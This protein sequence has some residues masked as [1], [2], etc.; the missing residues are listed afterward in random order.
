MICWTRT[1]TCVWCEFMANPSTVEAQIRFALSQLPAHNAHH[2]FEHICRYLTQQFICSN[3]LPATG[4]V[5]SGGDQGRDFETFRTY[6]LEELGPH[7]AFLGLVNEGTIAFICTIQTNGVLSKLRHDIKTVCTSGHS[8][9]EIRAFTLASVPV[10][11]RHKLEK[12]SKETYGI[13]IEFHDAESI[14]NLLARPEGFWIAEQFLSIPSEIRP[15]ANLDEGLSSEYSDR[16]SRW[17]QK[18]SIVPT[19]GEFIDLK[20]G[21]REAVFH[22]EAYADLPFWLGNLRHL[23]AIPELP[24]HIQQRARY[25]L[26]VATLRGTADFKP[27]DDVARIYF[28][29]SLRETEPARLQDACT[30]LLY[31]NSAV[32]TGLSSLMAAEIDNWNMR[33][34]RQVKCQLTCETPHRK[35]SLLYALGFLGVHPVP[36]ENHCPD[37]SFKARMH[38][39][40]SLGYDPT[41]SIDFSSNAHDLRFTD[42]SRALSAWTDLAN[43]LEG[44]PLFPIQNLA[45]ILQL[46]FPLWSNQGEWRELLNLVEASLEKRI[47]KYVLADRARERAIM[48]LNAERR[49]EALEELHRVKNDWWTG[50]TV[51]GSL[52]AMILIARTYLE[53]RLPQAAKSYALAAAYIA[54]S[55]SDEEL[56]DLIPTGLLMAASADFMAGA[57]CSATGLY[58]L[59]LI[60]QFQLIEDKDDTEK[61]EMQQIA[62]SHLSYII[63]CARFID[64]VLASSIETATARIGANEIINEVIKTPEVKFDDY[65]K[66][67]GSEELVSK[68]FSDL[69]KQRYLRFSALGTDWTLVVD[70]DI[71]SVRMAEGFAAA[72]QVILAALHREDMCLIQTK[73]QVR[74]ERGVGSDL[75]DADRVESLPRNEGREWVVRL[76]PANALNVEQYQEFKFELLTMATLILR[77]ASL[78]PKAD[79]SMS[80]ERAFQRGLGHM[81]APARPYEELAAAFAPS[82]ETEI[83]RCRFN[84]P[85]DS[86]E[87]ELL[88]HD[89]LKWQCGPGPTYSRKKAKKILNKRYQSL[90]SGLRITRVRLAASSEFQ[91]TLQSLRSNGWLDWHILIAIFNIVINHR[92]PITLSEQS[93]EEGKEQLTTAALQA[94]SGADAP[95][96][97]GLLSFEN[98]NIHRRTAMMSLV[99]FWDLECHQETPDFPAIEQFLADRYGYWDDDVPHDDPFAAPIEMKGKGGLLIVRDEVDDGR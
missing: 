87:G 83:S 92:N 26:V 76:S 82:I 36:E 78:L 58:E 11:T 12:E 72:V 4:P 51:R 44:T 96:P 91:K 85:W 22:K 37:G 98:I 70:N 95:I 48:L 55:N 84:A 16:R 89:E 53:L 69:G 74:I 43:G 71:E 29:E 5:S 90:A 42:E 57:W 13:E 97:L 79:F 18:D 28:D 67:F 1:N 3:V 68:P 35:A 23:L 61:A 64:P 7:G 17:R 8:V 27:V 40:R 6:L 31:A 66:S 62:L 30:L 63:A 39:L 99:N 94:E 60:T 88:P 14:A 47:G 73:I 20:S 77:E 25:E 54:V 19:L 34:T 80:L 52:L 9:H 21:L 46:L 49:L 24:A 41:M 32:G 86:R 75:P 38:E 10:G 56:V 15:N 65:W 50:E 93:L 33:L 2:D 45:D 59:G 81:L